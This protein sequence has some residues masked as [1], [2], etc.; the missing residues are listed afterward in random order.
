MLFYFL[1][2]T[3]VFIPVAEKWEQNALFRWFAK[4]G[5]WIFIDRYNP[6]IKALRKIISLMEQGN[7]LVIAPEGTRSRSMPRWRRANLAPVI[8]PQN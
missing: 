8:S 2:R 4:Y 6:D 3:D 7:I 5:N 1:D